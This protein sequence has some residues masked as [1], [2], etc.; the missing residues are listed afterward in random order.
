MGVY[1]STYIGPYIEADIEKKNVNSIILVNPI[2][3]TTFKE[4]KFDPESGIELKEMITI[5]EVQIDPDPYID[6][7]TVDLDEDMFYSPEWMET[8]ESTEI[9]LLNGNDNEC[10]VFGL[11]EG[12]TLD[13]SGGGVL[14]PE[15]AIPAFIK[16]YTAYLEYY[17]N[18]KNYTIRIK[19]G[20][21]NYAS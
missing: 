5:K 8:P 21:I 7:E 9:F 11:G 4:G 16:K 12:E 17:R 13:V 1:H 18:V 3:G 2:T 14:P 15:E 19:Y 20:I 6:D 10:G